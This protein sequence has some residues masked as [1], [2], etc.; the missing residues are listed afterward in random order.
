MISFIVPYKDLLL[1]SNKFC[2]EKWVVYE[3]LEMMKKL[4]DE[5]PHCE[6]IIV[7]QGSTDGIE[8][9]VKSYKIFTYLY[10]EAVDD[11]IINVSKALNLGYFKA[12]NDIVASTCLDFRFSNIS[13][14]VGTIVIL[15]RMFDNIIVRPHLMKIDENGEVIK[16]FWYCPLVI[17]KKHLIEIGGL[18]ERFKDWGQEYDDLG[19][20]LVNKDLLEIRLP[21]VGWV[22]LWHPTTFEDESR[23]KYNEGP[24][25][26]VKY[27]LIRDN[28][29][30]NSKN[31]VNSYW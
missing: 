3:G 13:L 27:K 20:R 22:H 5:H 16:P 28:L 10:Q 21:F 14:F 2:R 11:C 18:D 4:L 31:L 26:D 7:D 29:D 6:V 19:F 17:L 1:S 8:D 12:K 9:L 30:N 25:G 15:F 24:D 23:A